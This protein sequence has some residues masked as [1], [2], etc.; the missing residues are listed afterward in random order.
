MRSAHAH[1]TARRAR[2][3]ALVA[4]LVSAVAATGVVAASSARATTLTFQG[5]SGPGDSIVV[6]RQGE[7]LENHLSPTGSVTAVL[8][9]THHTITSGAVTLDSAYSDL[10]PIGPFYGYVRADFEQVGSISG[11]LANTATEGIQAVTVHTVTR[12]RM[13]V[14]A[15]PNPEE[16]PDT[17]GQLSSPS[18]CWVDLDL[19]LTGTVNRRTGFLSIG[20]NPFTIPEFPG[21]ATAT[22]DQDCGEVGFQALNSIVAG[23]NNRITMNFSGTPTTV[24]YTGVTSGSQSTIVIRKG[25]P[26]F[27]RT[28]HPAGSL[29]ADIDFRTNTINNVVT[30]FD[31]LNIPALPG[32]LASF[33]VYARIGMKILG[34]PTATLTPGTTVG[35]DNVTV[36]AKV[37]MAVTVSAVS[38]SLTLTNPNTCYVDLRLNLAGTVDRGTDKL[39]LSSKFSIPPFPLLGCGLLSAGLTTMV[40][41]SNNVANL[42]Y[43]DGDVS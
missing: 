22:S 41:G 19:A 33:P 7:S 6:T 23:S 10:V 24:H 4:T 30:K 3:A 18:T 8:D 25:D 2:R 21:G 37:R 11:T 5:T 38:S 14:F 20:A 26:I 13:T 28:V 40:S 15:T 39:S 32:L 35:I 9:D 42:N 29:V 27:E 17:D 36:S 34:T 43:V 12:L 1:T 16:H 31:D